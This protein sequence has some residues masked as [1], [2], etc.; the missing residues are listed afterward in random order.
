V[1]VKLEGGGAANGAATG[2]GVGDVNGGGGWGTLVAVP[3]EVLRAYKL[4]DEPF[5]DAHLAVLYVHTIMTMQS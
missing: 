5:S 1:E 4:A 2:G 3:R